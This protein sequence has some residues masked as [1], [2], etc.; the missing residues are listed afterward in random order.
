M[1]LLVLGGTQFVGRHLVEAALAQGH[2]LTLFNRGQTGAALFPAS[3]QLRRVQG[4]R[5]G[6]LSGLAQGE[7]D[8][9]LDCCAYLPREVE[10]MARL[11]QGRVGRYLLVS[12]V[13]AYASFAAPN[14]EDSPLGV[15]ID[16]LTEEVAGANYGPL[17]AACEAQLRQHFAQAFT[18]VRPSLVVGPYDP[19]Q[20]FTY[21]PARI[22][23][24]R[25]GEQLLMPITDEAPLQFIDARDLAEFI[26]HLL[27]SDR[28]GVFNAASTPGSI[29]GR[30]LLQA[31]V[32]ATGLGFEPSWRRADLAPL[33]AQ[34][35][36]PWVDLPL[37]LPAE[38]E[39]AAF[40]RCENQAA[41]EAGLRLRPL[42]DTVADT[43]AWW[44]RLPAAEQV[45]SKAGLSPERE[46]A[47]SQALSVS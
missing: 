41:L 30:D 6:D 40:M 44:R 38:P 32:Q 19:T 22:G 37:C 21:W 29:L 12:S 2:E 42:L 16:P 28:S 35:L 26:L 3:A 23:R 18:I 9:V 43:W 45:F 15:L 34:G 10:A 46:A 24:A 27:A 25:P 13:S 5:R 14:R 47:V 1:R 11:L 33:M 39:Y 8:A 4:D 7:W 31:C 17:K 20:R 36:R